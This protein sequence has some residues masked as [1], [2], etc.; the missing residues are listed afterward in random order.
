[1]SY[2]AFDLRIGIVE[3]FADAAK[4]AAYRAEYTELPRR[5]GHIYHVPQPRPKLTPE[6]RAE[7]KA[8][9]RAATRATMARLRAERR[10]VTP[11]QIV[12]DTAKKGP[13]PGH[14]YSE[15][16]NCGARSASHRCPVLEGKT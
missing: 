13:Y 14:A 8:R 2:A 3:L 5:L 10:G 12:R 9:H 6:E 1:V 16:L 7:R 11:G 15:C 4:M